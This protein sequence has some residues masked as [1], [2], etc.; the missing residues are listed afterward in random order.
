MRGF[1]MFYQCAA[2]VGL[3]LVAACGDTTGFD[4]P[5]DIDFRMQRI[6][7]GMMMQV[8]SGLAFQLAGAA[9]AISPDTVASLTVTVD[10]IQALPSGGDD[11]DD[12]AWV[13]VLLAAPV[14]L[15]LKALPTSGAS[16]IV[17]ASGTVDAGTYANV[18]LF[19]SDAV[20]VFTGPLSLGVAITL[21]GGTEY[22]VT[23][24][25]GAQTG[26]KTDAGFEATAGADVDLLFDESAT[27]GN[28][29]ATGT[30][31]IVLAPVIRGDPEA[32]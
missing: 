29:T 6:D 22:P 5:V 19:I 3:V 24:P 2:T 16:P 8:T 1:H 20:I 30:G 21:D 7:D 25:S 13:T 32:S 15:D 12:G 23:V 4:E 18:R 9:A 14:T 10:S 17:I 28:V 27:F 26:L 11:D 31:T